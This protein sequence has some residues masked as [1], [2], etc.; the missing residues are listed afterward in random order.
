MP[1]ATTDQVNL[2]KEDMLEH[3]MAMS[4]KQDDTDDTEGRF[5]HQSQCSLIPVGLTTTEETQEEEDML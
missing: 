3:A 2:L 4:L 1:G 5:Q